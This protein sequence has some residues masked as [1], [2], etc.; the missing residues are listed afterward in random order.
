MA[1]AGWLTALSVSAVVAVNAAGLWGIAA[2]RVNVAEQAAGVLQV[3]TAAR[4]R[5]LEATLAATRDDL[6]FLRDAAPAEAAVLLFLRGHPEV[7]RVLVRSEGVPRLH[8]GRRGTVP[9]LWLSSNPTGDEGVAVA[10]GRPRLIT[11]IPPPASDPRAAEIEA[12]IDPVALLERGGAADPT[13]SCSLADGADVSLAQTGPPPRTE[14][15][16]SADAAVSVSG[17]SPPGPWR[18]SCARS[19]Q[20][21]VAFL[22][23]VAHRYRTTLALNAAA[24]GLAVLLGGFAIHQAVRR[25]R[26]EARAREEARVRELER[27]LWHSERLATV[28]RLAAGIAHEIN[29]PLEGMANYL[30]LARDAL[31]QGDRDAAGR[32]LASVGEGLSRAAS[33]VRQVLD[34]ADPATAPQAALDLNPVFGQAV[35]FVRSRREFQSIRFGVELA[36]GGLRVR[37]SAVMLGQVALNLLVNACEAQPQGGEVLVRTRRDGDRAEAEVKDRGPGLSAGERERIFEPFYSTKNSTGLGLAICHSIARQH[38]G[39]L[40]AD[41]R[42][43]GGAV[44]RLRLPLLREP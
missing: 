5:A 39:E 3:E 2:A 30:S 23:P 10:A 4:A 7:R 34:H 38:D 16:L 12:E 35:E 11:R 28:G 27:Q 19:E 13:A 17:W 26:L 25:E 14:G 20:A 33:I 1:T 21:A 24:M 32:R 40:R 29:N 31:A 9:V 43:G 18:L 36:E 8:A 22:E 44:F 15:S 41:P 37:G 42:E 6:A